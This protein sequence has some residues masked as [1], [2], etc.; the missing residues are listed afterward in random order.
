MLSE[1][2]L[3]V[4]KLYFNQISWMELGYPIKV[5]THDFIDLINYV[6]QDPTSKKNK[7]LMSRAILEIKMLLKR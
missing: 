4:G 2:K 7:V 3:L 1:L 6:S 5:L